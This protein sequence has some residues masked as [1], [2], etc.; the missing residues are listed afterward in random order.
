MSKNLDDV[1]SLP[2]NTP[3]QHNQTLNLLTSQTTSNMFDSL[4]VLA[5]VEY[6]DLINGIDQWSIRRFRDRHSTANEVN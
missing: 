1:I 2:V 4:P 6:S 5:V 3:V